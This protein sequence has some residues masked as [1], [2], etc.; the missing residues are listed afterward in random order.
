[1]QNRHGV[2][3]DLMQPDMN[4]ATGYKACRGIKVSPMIRIADEMTNVHQQRFAGIVPGRISANYPLESSFAEC[5]PLREIEPNKKRRDRPVLR[6]K[7]SKS[8]R[9]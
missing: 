9:S 2:I 4:A 8:V 3:H 6:Q 5:A 7:I 1:M